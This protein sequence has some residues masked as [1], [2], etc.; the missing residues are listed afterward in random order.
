MEQR[1]YIGQ[2]TR[3]KEAPRHVA[4]RGRFVDDLVLPRMLHACI[5]R[6]PY[7]HARITSVNGDG[8]AGLHGVMGVVTPDDVTRMSRPFKPGRYAAGLRVPIPSTLRHRQGALRWRTRCDGRGRHAGKG[9]DRLDLIEI[10][11]KPP[12]HHDN[13][14]SGQSVRAPL[15]RRM[16]SNVAWRGMV[17]R[18][19]ECAHLRRRHRRPRA[20]EDSPIQLDASRALRLSCRIHSG[21]V[22]GGCNAQSPEACTG[23]DRSA[24]ID[25]VAS[26]CRISGRFGQ[27]IHTDR[28]NRR[29]DGTH[30]HQDRRPVKWI[31]DRSEHMM[32]GG[33]S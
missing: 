28:G 3:S 31:E 30:G 17:L 29:A 7:G 2:S 26:S 27:K 22:D 12:G 13:G 25:T 33:H 11:M 10:D 1:R 9:E 8:A 21:A 19:I 20:P 18:D 23:V 14:G 16:G 24:G 4:G 5:L 15:Y 6:S 32:A